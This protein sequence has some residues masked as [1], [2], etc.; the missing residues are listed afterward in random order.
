MAT[1]MALFDAGKR[2]R[3]RLYEL[4]QDGRYV[5]VEREG[6]ARLMAY[7]HLLL[8]RFLV[9]P[10]FGDASAEYDEPL[11]SADAGVEASTL[12]KP[13]Q[14]DSQQPIYDATHT[15][16]DALKAVTASVPR[17]FKLAPK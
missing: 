13:A 15:A 17:P 14:P 3:E 6:F 7:Y 16:A 8:E 4:S 10:A 12:C 5:A 9:A 2:L 11:A 1:Q